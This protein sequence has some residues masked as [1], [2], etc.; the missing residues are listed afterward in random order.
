MRPLQLR[1]ATMPIDI[2]EFGKM[3]DVSPLQPSK[4]SIEDNPIK[5]C[6][7]SNDVIS[8][9]FKKTLFKVFTEAA[10]I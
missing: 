2:I 7:S 4:P 3:T 5:Y 8:V 1:K 10:S 6:N 9:L